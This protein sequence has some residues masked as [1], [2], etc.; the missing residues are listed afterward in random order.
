MAD[1][2]QNRQAKTEQD[3]KS[4]KKK[5]CE[6]AIIILLSAFLLGF[7]FFSTFRST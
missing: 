7:S 3:K 4:Q 2:N 1:K 6:M 5:C